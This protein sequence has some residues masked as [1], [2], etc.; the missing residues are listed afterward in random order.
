MKLGRRSFL[1]FG[2]AAAAVGHFRLPAF[3]QTPGGAL[4]AAVPREILTLDGNYANL[5]ENDILGLLI[6]DALFAVDPVNASAVPL[7]AQSHEFS[8]ESTLVIT[9]RDDVFFH[10]GEPLTVEDV[11]YTYGYLLDPATQNSYQ[12]RFSHWL[13]SVEA[14]DERKVR[15]N[16]KF[17]YAMAP[18]DLA[19]Y[20]KL[21]RKN[22]YSG[23]GGGVDPNAHT[24]RLNG[25]GPYRV[26]SFRPG[27]EVRLQRF[28]R[29]RAGGPKGEPQIGEIVIRIIPD[30]STQAAEVM[31]GG[32]HWTFGMPDTVAEGAHSTGL[33]QLTSGPS[34]RNYYIS[35]DAAG[36]VQ[37]GGPLTKVEVRR[38]INHAIDRQ[39]ILANLRGGK[40]SVLKTACIP[41]Q[42]GCLQDGVTEYAYDPDRARA[43]LAEAGHAGGFATEL[44]AA[45]DEDVVAAVAEQLVQVGI[46]VAV[47]QVKGPSLTQARREQ[48]IPMEWASSGSFGI[49]D[50][51]A[52]MLDRLGPGSSRNYSGDE[53]MSK[54]VLAAVSTFDPAERQ[55]QFGEALK[56]MADQA[57]WVPMYTDDQNYLMAP[58]LAYKG[59][60]DGMDRLYSASWS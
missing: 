59:F 19:M 55:T 36:L 46:R 24:L 32:V 45:R 37:P 43:L 57:Y 38:A 5:R 8:D 34:L 3:A 22:S 14:V 12:S 7:A 4:I 33:V 10:D 40:G 53:A 6:D 42:F 20:S 49:P 47:R 51:G 11:V 35:M 26:V 48:K 29:Y 50:A 31:S 52:I 58:N 41:T 13:A 15:F 30:W 56:I 23:A 60:A 16:M 44:W 21:R 1:A 17:P 27:Q 25:T 2:A 18:F 39:S 54:A 9:I 28:E